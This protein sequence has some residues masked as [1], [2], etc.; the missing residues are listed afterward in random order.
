[1]QP[2]LPVVVVAG[3]IERDDDVLLA[4]RPAGSH[5][6]HTWEFPG[7]KLGPGESPEAALRREIWEEL[8]IQVEVGGI[9]H[10]HYHVYASG[11]VLLLVYRCCLVSGEPRG[12]EGQACAWV[13]RGSML[14]MPLAPADVPAARALVDLERGRGIRGASCRGEVPDGDEPG[15]PGKSRAG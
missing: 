1:M 10:I 5:L 4:T 11:P 8:G 12:L 3:L 14:E 2:S 7:G 9:F 15:G 13:P 6:E